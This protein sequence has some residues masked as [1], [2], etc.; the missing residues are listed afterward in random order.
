MIHN[1]T[2]RFTTLE[3][4]IDAY[5]FPSCCRKAIESGISEVVFGSIDPHPIVDGRG[6]RTLENAGIKTRSVLTEETDKL[7][8]EWIKKWRS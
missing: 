6:I 5:T 4:C 8:S 1:R 3:P 7:I 2:Q